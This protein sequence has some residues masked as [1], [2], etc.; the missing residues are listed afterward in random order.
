MKPRNRGAKTAKTAEK[1]SSIR[2]VIKFHDAG[3]FIMYYEYF[4]SLN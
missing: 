4:G 3:V 1:R 2:C